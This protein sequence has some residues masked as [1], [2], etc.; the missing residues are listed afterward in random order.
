MKQTGIWFQQIRGPF[1][2]LS[3]V[4]VLLGVAVARYDGF[5]QWNHAFL[6]CTGVI[7]THIS[8]NLFNELSDF[9]TRI[10][11]NTK[12]TPFSGG[13]G[14]LQSGATSPKSVRNAAYGT[15][16]ISALIGLYF[17][18]ISGWPIL[19][20]MIIGGLSI[21]FYTTHFSHWLLG[22]LLSGMALGSFVVLGVYFALSSTLTVQV[23]IVSIPPGILTSLLL[24]L[25]EFPDAEADKEGGR[26]HL[27][28]HLGKS[29][30]AKV[31]VFGLILVY[32]CILCAPAFFHAPYLILISWLTI[33]FALKA[34]QGTLRFYDDLPNLIPA[35]GMNVGVVLL[36]DLLLAIGYFITP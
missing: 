22:E 16:I 11:T 34:I 35:L 23:V 13:S 21:R 33:P 19:I 14:M 36:T 10:D 18:F 15:M 8:V 27:V 12:Q 29:R 3:I 25:N 2:I 20:F 28:I 30:A 26:H 4:L 17:C 1:L 31:Y 32:L 5:V 6:L 9:K 7:L 24:F